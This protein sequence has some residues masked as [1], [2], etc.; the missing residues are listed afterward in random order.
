MNILNPDFS[1]YNELLE[2][3]KEIYN[4]SNP[5][6]LEEKYKKIIHLTFINKDSALSYYVFLKISKQSELAIKYLKEIKVLANDFDL[7]KNYQHLPKKISLLLDKYLGTCF[8]EHFKYKGINS[9]REG[10]DKHLEEQ[11]LFLNKLRDNKS[12]LLTKGNYNSFQKTTE[13]KELYEQIKNYLVVYNRLYKE[14][15]NYIKEIN[16]LKAY[17]QSEQKKEKLLYKLIM[18]EIYENIKTYIPQNIKNLIDKRFKTA[19]GK[20]DFLLDFDYEES[21]FE[22]FSS[23]YDKILEKDNTITSEKI[24]ITQARLA[25]LE[26][27]GLPVSTN[28]YK[29]Y[30]S[31]I[32]NPEIKKYLPPKT[33]IDIIKAQKTLYKV[34]FNRLM[35]TENPL[36]I[37]AVTKLSNPYPDFNLNFSSDKKALTEHLYKIYLQKNS[38]MFPIVLENEEKKELI[39][40]IFQIIKNID[41]TVIDY[42]YLHELVHAIELNERK[43][44]WFTGF[45]YLNDEVNP[46]NK[47]KRK[48][49]RLNETIADIIVE[50]IRKKLKKRGIYIAEERKLQDT[51]YVKN[52]NSNNLLKIMLHPL[53]NN[54]EQEILDAR[55]TG[56]LEA[57]FDLIG[58]ENYEKLNNAINHLD[59]LISNENLTLKLKQNN[60]RDTTVLEYQ[61]IKNEINEIYENIFNN[62]ATSKQAYQ[63]K[64]GS[65]I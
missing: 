41:C 31:I 63:K 42:V 6:L 15:M 14:Y 53:F 17:Y 20:A 55:L 34:S 58:K 60:Q 51:K 30:N 2:V 9:F 59:F 12:P 10:K 62:T 18:L 4:S 13:F 19:D 27:L 65:V 28:D 37:K 16:Y 11:I 35:I 56:N 5:Q 61:Q 43:D 44:A 36:F 54:F 1:K 48:Y 50:K 32:N 39:P 38:C 40:V 46:Y 45:D 64:K 49:E 57:F 22:Y 23:K 3:L 7:R 33:L 24:I 26:V 8:D 25:Y 21:L 29:N 52:R 47:K